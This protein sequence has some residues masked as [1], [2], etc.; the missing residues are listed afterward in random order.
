VDLNDALEQFDRVDA[1]LSRLENILTRHR[2]LIPDGIVFSGGSPEE[3]Q[4]EDLRSAF[5]EVAAA[6]PSIDGWRI[7]SD[8]LPLDEIAQNRLDAAE[9]DEVQISIDLAAT[10]SRPAQDVSEYRRR[11]S[12]QRRALVRDRA[13]QLVG[14]IDE[15]LTTLIAKADRSGELVVDPEWERFKLA[16][17]EIERLLGDSIA[18]RGR[19]SELKRHLAFGQWGDAH[20]IADFDWPSIREHIDGAL[21]DEL[22]PIPIGIGDLAEVVSRRPEGAVSSR[23]AWER[24]SAEHFER[25]IYNLFAHTAGYE[26]VTWAMRTNAP[27]RGRDI[28]A[29]RVKVDPL[30]GVQRSRVIVQCK[31]WTSRSI[32]ASVVASEVATVNL[33]DNPPADVLI[34]VTSGRFTADALVAIEQHNARRDHPTIEYWPESHLE[35]LLAQRPGLVAEF[36]VRA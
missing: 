5:A 13:R 19:W 15:A 2:E 32:G 21:Y 36:D 16:F 12:K 11:F 27:D 33:W 24:L 30:S 25:L 3:L 9:I 10:M 29:D 6:L 14:E 7:E 4:A 20:D 17:G 22:E 8:L 34:L 18:H 1:N 31:H 23:L 28:T 26:N 35:S